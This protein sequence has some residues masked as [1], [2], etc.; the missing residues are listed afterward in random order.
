VI[1]SKLAVLAR[2]GAA[3]VLAAKGAVKLFVAEIGSAVGRAIG[4]VVAKPLAGTTVVDTGIMSVT[5]EW[6][7]VKGQSVTVSGH[8]EMVRTDVE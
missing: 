1:V 5:V 7:V 2:T 8:S 4:L 3:V 6:E